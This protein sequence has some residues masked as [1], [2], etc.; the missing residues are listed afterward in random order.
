MSE[1]FCSKCEELTE[2]TYDFGDTDTTDQLL[3]L[4]DSLATYLA[5][6]STERFYGPGSVYGLNPKKL[7]DLFYRVATHLEKQLIPNNK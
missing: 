5:H 1:L 7:E 4:A 2:K 6:A 3:R